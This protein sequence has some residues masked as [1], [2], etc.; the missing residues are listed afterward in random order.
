MNHVHVQSTL[1]FAPSSFHVHVASQF[2]FLTSE[3]FKMIPKHEI[4][5][6]CL[7]AQ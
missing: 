3:G 1:A 5:E 7:A 6:N 4:A 2:A